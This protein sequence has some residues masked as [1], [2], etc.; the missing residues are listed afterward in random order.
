[1]DDM[2]MDGAEAG[3]GHADEAVAGAGHVCGEGCPDEWEKV[4][5]IDMRTGD[6][7]AGE[8]RSCF[9]GDLA[10]TLVSVATGC[11]SFED[12]PRKDIL[13]DDPDGSPLVVCLLCV[14]AISFMLCSVRAVLEIPQ[15]LGRSEVRALFAAH[16][17]KIA[18]R[19][20]DHA[21]RW[22]SSW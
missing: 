16:E 18:A 20:A 22:V 14:A 2:T 15:Q 9:L 10:A 12:V 19:E 3:A 11:G 7:R 1:M 8:C 4:F 17:A 5:W 13:Y 21:A 6:V